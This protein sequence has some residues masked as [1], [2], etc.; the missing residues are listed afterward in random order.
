M[1]YKD[2][3]II[4][5]LFDLWKVHEFGGNLYLLTSIYSKT[6]LEQSLKNGQNKG[7]KDKWQLHEG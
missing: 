7:L 5:D 4:C 6:C 3:S 2:F 1:M